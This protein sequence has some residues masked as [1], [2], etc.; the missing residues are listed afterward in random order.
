MK[1]IVKPVLFLWLILL[2]CL[3]LNSFVIAQEINL[4]KMEKCG[5][6]LCYQS[7]DDAN[8]FMYLPD[9]PR[10]AYKDGRPQFSFLKYA[11][12]EETGEAGTGRAKGGGIVHFLVTYGAD[13]ARV[14]AAE[15][16]LQ[17]KLPDARIAGPIIYR[18]GSFALITSF[19]EDNQTTTR[20]VAVGKAPLMEGQKAAVS[21][22]LTR[23]GAE[24]LWESFQT[25]TPDISLVFDMQFAGVREPYEATLEADWARIVKHDQVKA[26]VKYAW[27]GA[28]VDLLFQEL[29]QD[30]AIKI[31]TR[32]KDANLDKILQSAHAKLL[33][34]IFDPAP[35]DELT[36]AAAEKDSYSNLNQAVQLLKGAAASRRSKGKRSW[37]PGGSRFLVAGLGANQAA[38]GDEFVEQYPFLDWLVRKANAADSSPQM[39]EAVA[40]FNKANVLRDADKCVEAIPL[41]EKASSLNKAVKGHESA[42]AV[43]NLGVCNYRL[44]NWDAASSYFQKFISPLPKSANNEK[45]K[46]SA[47]AYIGGCYQA[48]GNNDQA[49][50]YLKKAEEDPSGKYADTLYMVANVYYDMESYAKSASYY[51]KALAVAEAGSSAERRAKRWATETAAKAYTHARK[52]DEAARSEKYEL[53]KCQLALDAYLDYQDYLVPTGQRAKEVENR[54]QFLSNKMEAKGAGNVVAS[55]GESGAKVPAASSNGKPSSSVAGGGKGTGVKSSTSAPKPTAGGSK[56]VKSAPRAG[57]GKRE[58]ASKPK[59]RKKAPKKTKTA[60]ARSDGSPGFSLVASYKMKRIKRSGKFTYHLNHYRNEVQAFAMAENIGDLFARYGHDPKVFRAVTIDDPVF[61]QREIMVTLDGQ[62]TQTFT[63]HLNFVTVQMEKRHQS[64]ALTLDEV[65]I[66]P[67]KFNANGNSFVLSYGWKGDDDRTKW[68]DYR[69][70]ALWSFHGGVEIRQP[71][72]PENSAML[73]LEPPHRYRMITIEGDGKQLSHHGVRH[74]VVTVTSDIGGKPVTN[75]VTIRN[76]GIAPSMVMEVPES[77]EGLPSQVEITW[78]LKGGKKVTAP[79]QMVEGDIIYWDELPEG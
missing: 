78:Y 79:V 35:V 48:L 61:K 36:R 38:N 4:D 15:A 66:T 50:A 64:G 5:D 2:G 7:M 69:V 8:V 34:V 60:A 27:F 53:E 28:D 67:E 75:R 33:K 70:Q 54:I 39:Q 40:L 14:S 55:G 65:I 20:T 31:T 32:G 51:K 52:L 25:A 68:L 11:R 77:R 49:L 26:G 6:L 37:L 46:G 30:G 57:S 59:G 12:V 24:L 47:Y 45:L 13:K 71:W 3:C 74:A 19:Q 76:L 9:Q 22:A 58:T 42:G 63:S 21:M 23:E 10:L 43:F 18:K 16:A 56:S 62:D 1:N 73:A 41:Y 44:E 17:E 29:R 72:D